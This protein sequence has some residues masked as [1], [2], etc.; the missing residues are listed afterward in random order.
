MGKCV[1][2]FYTFLVNCSVLRPRKLN[3]YPQFFPHFSVGFIGADTDTTCSEAAGVISH[4]TSS[5]VP[6]YSTRSRVTSQW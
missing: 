2:H 1:K 6:L 5:T 3:K 4:K